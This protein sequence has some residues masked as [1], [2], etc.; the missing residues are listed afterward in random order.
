MATKSI[1]VPL[2]RGMEATEHGKQPACLNKPPK[3]KGYPVHIHDGM[4]STNARTGTSEW[5]G[6]GA[7]Y[8]GAPGNPLNAGPPRGKRLSPPMPSP[9]MRSRTNEGKAL[10]SLADLG[11]LIL[12]EAANNS[13]PDDRRALGIGTL[14]TAVNEE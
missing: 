10:R 11:K 1:D 7:S 14:P 4:R 5:G 6:H 8:D 3:A 12:D 9:G 2:A 13:A